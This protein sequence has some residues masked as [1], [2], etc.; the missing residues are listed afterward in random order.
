MSEIDKC[1]IP[2]CDLHYNDVI[3]LLSLS[4]LIY[5]YNFTKT[6]SLEDDTILNFI[7]RIKLLTIDKKQDDLSETKLKALDHINI[8]MSDGLIKE[9]ISDP[10]TDLQ[11][12]ITTSE[13][14]KRINIIFRV[15]ESTYDWLHDLNFIKTCIDKENNVYVHKGFYNQ[16]TINDNH[17]KLILQVQELIKN[18][19][20]Y[21]IF[22]TG[23][24]LG[25]GL[26]SL[27][28]YLLSKEISNNITIISFA[29]PRVGNYGW[30]KSFNKQENLTYYRFVNCNDVVTAFPSLLF[31]HVGQAIRLK[32][33]GR[34][35]LLEKKYSWSEFTLFKCYS[36]TDHF[37]GEYYKNLLKVQ[38][39]NPIKI[40]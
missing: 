17:K 21:N 8:N 9:F 3:D 4:F 1:F 22:I 11:V 33:D 20:D 14:N 15:S 40:D 16:L 23:H 2:G 28:G 34:V 37:C 38:S 25:A 18:N 19:P 7:D 26:S 35:K 13:R 32:C 12:G 36:P 29:S 5:N 6:N 10:D 39:N 30:Y 31:Y 24:S 27:F